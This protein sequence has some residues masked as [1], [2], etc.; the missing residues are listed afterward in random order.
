MTAI[1]MKTKLLILLSILFT[2]LG[3]NQNLLENGDFENGT[4]G[5]YLIEE[6]DGTSVSITNADVFQG[7]S[8]LKLEILNPETVIVAGILQ[9]IAVEPNTTY[10]F[11]HSI[12]TEALNYI[13]YPYMKLND[14]TE[15]FV[16]NGYFSGYTKDWTTYDMRFTTPDLVNSLDFFIFLVGNNG[17][18]CIDN[19]VLSKIESPEDLS[20]SVDLSNS[21]ASFNHLLLST[22]SSPI[23]PNSANDLSDDFIEIGIPEVRTHD[24]YDACDIHVIFPDF[25]ADPL[26]PNSYDFSATDDVMQSII[27]VDASPFF[28]LGYSFQ[29]DPI[30]GTPPADFDKWA[31]ICAQIVK[32]YNEGWNNG[33]YFDIEKWEVWN[34]PDLG[35]FWSG[36]PQQFYDLYQQTVLM[37][38]NVN[39]NL[40]VGAAGFANIYNADFVQPFFDSISANNTPIDFISYHAYTYTNP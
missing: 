16:Q 18:A 5:W 23:R 10:Y 28:R 6:D 11:S 13:A 8:S 36:T 1:Y 22:N 31:S 26:D 12:K 33:F 27:D 14:G 38:K 3:F 35:H 17:N 32:H 20:F 2:Q 21:T 39:P 24:I 7:N 25:S 4:T 40:K 37:I 9:S 15:I 19:L 29:L 34:E 30:Y